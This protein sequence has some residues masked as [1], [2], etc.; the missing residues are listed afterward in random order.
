MPRVAHNLLVRHTVSIG[1]GDEARPH[2]MR[3]RRLK[4]G[5]LD[6]RRRGA[7]SKDLANGIRVKALPTDR[8]PLRDP[9]KHRPITD[10]CSTQPGAQRPNGAGVFLGATHD[11]NLG[12]F[13]LWI[14]LGAGDHQPQPGPRRSDMGDIEADQLGAAQRTREADQQQGAV[15]K[16]GEIVA[17]NLDQQPD[18]PRGQRADRRAGSPWVRDCGAQ[19]ICHGSIKAQFLTRGKGDYRVSPHCSPRH[20]LK[21]TG[22]AK[23]FGEKI[24]GTTADRPQLRKLMAVLK[25]GDVMI[26]PAVGVLM[27]PSRRGHSDPHDPIRR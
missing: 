8:A 20:Q 16:A 5:S 21:A 6:S 23:I 17:A 25:H 18:L 26:T 13:T 3:R 12:A 2:A 24:T 4:Q 27:E 11:P 7:S 9:A 1:R 22:C 14:G 15:P 19:S 10:L